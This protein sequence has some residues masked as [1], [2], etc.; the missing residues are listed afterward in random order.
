MEYPNLSKAGR[1]RTPC[2][3]LASL[4]LNGATECLVPSHVFLLGF[5][6][7]IFFMKGLD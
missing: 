5:F 4:Q 7:F 3:K 1:E 6:R 2:W